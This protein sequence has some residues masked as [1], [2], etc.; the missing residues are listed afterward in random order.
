MPLDQTSVAAGVG[1]SV[2]NVQ[3]KAVAETKPRKIGI[4]GTYDPSITTIADNEPDL[5][6]SPESAGAKYG[7]G[8]MV[9]RLAVQTSQGSQGIETWVIPQPEVTESPAAATGTIT[10]STQPTASGTIH[11]YIAG[12]YVPV[13]VLKADPVADVGD[14]IEAAIL[15]NDDLPVTA[16]A[17]AAVVTITSKSVGPWGDDISLKVNLGFQQEFPAS[18]TLAIVD[19]SGGAGLPDIQDALDGLG[20]GDDANQIDITDLVHGYGDDSDTLDKL[21]VYNGEGNEPVGLYSKTI[22]RPFRSIIGD[23]GIDTSPTITRL[24]DLI[25][26]ADG[27]KFDRTNGII[28]VP[29][30]PNHP[31]EIAAN[32]MGILARINNNRASQSYVGQILSGVIPGIPVDRWTRDYNDRNT[33]VKNGISPT[34]IEGNTVLLQ[35]VLTFYRPDN[36]PLSSNGYRSQRNIS[37]IQNMLY[38]VG[39]TFSQEKWQGISIVEDVDKVSNIIDRQKTKDIDA[40]IDE[41]QNLAVSFEGH[42]W[43]YTAAFTVARLATGDYVQIRT[44][45]TGFDAI[46]PVI[47]SIEGGII[48]TQ[49]EFDTSIAVLL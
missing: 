10:V 17:A 42:A 38:N 5:I 8:F 1:A 36:V 24:A 4:I 47:F 7:F 12:I 18:L 28:A 25:T 29:G 33:A 27:R 34:V 22:Y 37:I 40:V 31:A 13:T 35:N 48:D 43:I 46:L 30:S 49:V 23:V 44:N 19:M 16:S 45:S 15:A 2:K 21:S 14:A 20:L 41:L 6:T 9:H 39:L 26:L 11:L 32:T 3:F